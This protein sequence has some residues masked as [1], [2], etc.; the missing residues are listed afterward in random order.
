MPVENPRTYG[1]SP[2]NVVVIHG[3]PGAPGSM[4]PLGQALAAYCGVL[5]PLQTATSL[6][7][8]VQELRTVLI[9]NGEP[10]ATLLGSSWGAILGFIFSARYP[11]L[12]KK[13]ILIGSGVYEEQYATR[14]QET[15]LSRLGKEGKREAQSLI[16]TLNDPI[17]SDKNLPLTRLG[18]LFTK[19]DAYNPLTLNTEVID[20]QYHVYINVWNE[21]MEL[22][23]NGKLV[24]LGKQIQCPVVAIHGDYD[25]HPPEGIK[26]PLSAVL[27]N[28]RFILLKNCGHL[29]WIEKEAKDKFYGILKE[30]L[31]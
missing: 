4:A 26:K 21:A 7:G 13:L 5:E 11:K 18:E 24:A 8:Q 30:E 19:S 31:S 28:F 15:R 12:V 10:P 23:R 27:K 25:P 20:V 14:I 3:G 22:R 6:E 29:P 2:F 9:K 17:V 1:K 16:K